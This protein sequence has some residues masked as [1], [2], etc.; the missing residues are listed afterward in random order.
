MY[1]KVKTFI[2]S[3]NSKGIPVFM[4]R[5]PKTS[6]GSITASLVFISSTV[7]LLSLIGSVTQKVKGIDVNNAIEFY[8]ISLGAYLGRKYQSKNGQI[9]ESTTEK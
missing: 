3:M 9:I 5:D 6:C 2:N 1:D 7:V 4:I 8:L